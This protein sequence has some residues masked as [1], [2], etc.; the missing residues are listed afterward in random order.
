MNSFSEGN[1][2]EDILQRLLNNVS[3][4]IDKRQGS[5]IYDALAPAAAEIAQ[6]YI[7]LDVYSEQTYLQN[8]VGE[9][10]DNRASDY[11]IVRNQATPAIRIAEIYDS[12]NELMQVNIGDRFSVPNEYGGYNFYVSEEISKGNYLLTCETNGT[13]GNEYIGELLPLTN[14]NN[15]GKAIITGTQTPGDDEESDE[16]LRERVILI[17]NKKPFAGNKADYVEYV[18]NISG[19]GMSKIFPVW[20]GGGTVKVAFL[21]S[22]IKIPSSEF[23]NQVQT[24]IDP[25]QNQGEG[26]GIAP[27][28]HTVTVEAPSKLDIN[29]NIVV[30]MKSGY[31]ADQV[32]T[33]IK[34]AIQEYIYEIQK[35]WETDDT[36]IIYTSRVIAAVLGVEEVNNVVSVTINGSNS[37]YEID[38]TATNVLFPML[39]EVVVSES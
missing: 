11:G 32:K 35:Q 34:E 5:I 10:L 4:D 15:L 39:N 12:N 26:I 17:I 23:V 29:M 18:D 19:I 3:D 8:A 33:K 16:E 36:L 9:N 20:N 24:I 28:G 1:D 31:T 37:D 21:T 6:C 2:F 7:A 22:D 27:I 14:I 38:V 25:I 13:V 30:D